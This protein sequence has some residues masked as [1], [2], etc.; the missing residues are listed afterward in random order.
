MKGEIQSLTLSDT[1][2]DLNPGSISIRIVTFI[3]LLIYLL[4]CGLFINAVSRCYPGIYLEVPRKT[5]RNVSG[6][7]VPG[8]KFEPG[9]SRVQSKRADHSLVAV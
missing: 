8:P 1:G 3:Y 4:V 6:Q 7:Q 2:V 5:M 9:T